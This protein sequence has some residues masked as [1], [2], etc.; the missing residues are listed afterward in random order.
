MRLKYFC[1]LKNKFIVDL[2]KYEIDELRKLIVYY[3][4]DVNDILDE[5]FLEIAIEWYDK[6]QILITNEKMI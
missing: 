2:T 5:D 6:K 3:D 1:I 4:I